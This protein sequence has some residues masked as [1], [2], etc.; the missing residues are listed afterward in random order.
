MKKIT[1]SIFAFILLIFINACV[2]YEP[3][4][5]STNLQFEIT[6]YS[7]EGNKILGNEILSKLQRFS[8]SN[9][10]KK[11]IKSIDLSINTSK[12]KTATV[13]DN[14]GKI[15]EYKITLN[16]IIEVKDYLTSQ[17][18]LDETFISSLSYKVHDNYSDTIEAENRSIES[19]INKTYQELLI[20]LSQNIVTK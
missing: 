19:L 8:S 16:I 20:K 7:I 3:I 5:S 15:K 6:N 18:I 17:V 12:N 14:A 4:F 1:Y 13:K 9:D 10:D 11:N 2:G